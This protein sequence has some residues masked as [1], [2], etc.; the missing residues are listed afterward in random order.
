VISVF[1]SK[2]EPSE[3]PRETALLYLFYGCGWQP[4]TSAL[5]PTAAGI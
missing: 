3:K 5:I 4:A 1:R 2:A